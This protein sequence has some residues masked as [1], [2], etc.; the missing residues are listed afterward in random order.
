MMQSLKL[1]LGIAASKNDGKDK[2]HAKGK[3]VRRQRPVR[4]AS[5]RNSRKCVSR[6]DS[7]PEPAFDCYTRLVCRVANVRT[8]M[9]SFVDESTNRQFLKSA[10]ELPPGL[11]HSTLDKSF[12]KLVARTG[13]M[14]VVIDAR[15]DDRVIDNPDIKEL[16]VARRSR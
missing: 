1:I 13:E 3:V 6:I 5:R 11:N 12:C 2:C 7:P 16:G 4:R 14:L 10:K 9:V 15:L 8:A